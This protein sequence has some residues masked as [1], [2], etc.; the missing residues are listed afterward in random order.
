MPVYDAWTVLQ[1]LFRSHARC[2]GWHSRTRHL[3]GATK[4]TNPQY[5]DENEWAD[6]S[7]TC[8]CTHTRI[9]THTHAQQ[10]MSIC[11]YFSIWPVSAVSPLSPFLDLLMPTHSLFLL[12]LTNFKAFFN[13]QYLRHCCIGIC[14]S[15]EDSTH[16]VAWVGLLYSWIVLEIGILFITYK[17]LSRKETVLY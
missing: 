9:H 11:S 7:Y 13:A 4:A 3:T 1:R 6:A 17:D 10:C 14:E 8:T 12:A 16:A 15:C 2:R 5:A